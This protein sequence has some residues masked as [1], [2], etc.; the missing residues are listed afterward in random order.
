MTKVVSKARNAELKSQKMRSIAAEMDALKIGAGWTIEDLGKPQVMIQSTVGDSHPGSV[1]LGSLVGVAEKRIFELGGK[2]AKYSVTDICD[3]IAQGHDGMNYSLVSREV[4][5]SMIEVQLRATPFDGGVFIASCD[6]GIPA[7]LIA[8]ARCNEP[9]IFIPGGTMKTGVN[10][11]TLEQIGMYQA[12]FLKSEITQK[13]FDDYKKAACPGCGACQFMGTASTMQVMMESLGLTL[14]GASLLIAEGEELKSYAEKSAE[15]VMKLVEM[16]LTPDKI[17]T[18]KAFENAI[19]VHSAIAGSSNALLHLPVAARELGIEI[20]G[21]LFDRINRQIPFIVN[22]RPTG[23]FSVEYFRYAGGTPAVM[24]EIKEYLHLDALTVTGK[25]LGEN[26]EDLKKSNYYEL[27]EE[28]LKKIGIAK[29]DLIASI[30]EPIKKEG[31]IGILKG[32]IAPEG[33]VVK[34]AAVDKNMHK[35][36]G[37]ARPFNSEE[38]AYNAVITKQIVPGDIVI[39]R[40]EGPRGSGMPEMFYTTEAIAS[41]P[42]LSSTVALV[43]D[44]RFSGATRGPAIG[45]VSPEAAAGGPIALVEENDLIEIDIPNRGLN[46]VGVNNER[47]NEKEISEIF[48]E[49]KINYLNPKLEHKKGILRIYSKLASS[50]MKGGYME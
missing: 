21:D 16:N 35:T 27:G 10:D 28:Y 49:R 50:A 47:K 37:Q 46:V 19:M 4:I 14:P 9:S 32:N 44:G 25:T 48:E 31:S 20:D 36:I 40:Y 6:K 30:K 3:G 17:L 1:H 29:K 2:G 23:K 39:I 33:A 41:D 5:S 26:L 43:T 11:L 22:T 7:H 24:E 45:H 18:Q 15:Q 13:A 42:E 34:H 8:L 38:E 12:Q